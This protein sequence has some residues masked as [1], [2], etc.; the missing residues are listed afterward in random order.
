M[1]GPPPGWRERQAAARRLVPLSCGHTDPWIC[2]RDETAADPD[3]LAAVVVHLLATTGGPGLGHDLDAA[4]ALWRR[5]GPSARL[6]ER[7]FSLGG[8]AA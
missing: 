7:I 8:V 1:T 5:G 3:L 2:R 6:A 4:R